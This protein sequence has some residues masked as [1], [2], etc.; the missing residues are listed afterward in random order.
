MKKKIQVNFFSWSGIGPQRVKR[1][2]YDL[3]MSS[4]LNPLTNP[5]KMVKH[6]QTLYRQQPAYCFSV[7]NHCVELAFK[8]LKIVNGRDF[9]SACK[10]R[11]W[12]LQCHKVVI[13]NP[14]AC[15]NF[16][17]SMNFMDG[18][19][20]CGAGNLFKSF[21][22][23]T[24]TKKRFK[25]LKLSIETLQNFV[26]YVQSFWCLDYWFWTYFTHFSNGSIA[27]FKQ[28]NACWARF[29]TGASFVSKKRF[30]INSHKNRKNYRN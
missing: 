11:L 18:C 9:F 23:S 15:H 1:K 16:F 10:N 2:C 20:F 7:F 3:F 4:I 8:V 19:N 22:W 21:I 28:V 25:C 17:I 26:K 30:T 5:P 13:K 12:F 27:E 6:T 29:M 14:K 24:D